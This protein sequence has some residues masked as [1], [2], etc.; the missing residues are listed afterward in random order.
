M[1]ILLG[2]EESKMEKLRIYP[3]TR[4]ML[5]AL[6]AFLYHCIQ[7]DWHRYNDLKKEK[8]DAI[9]IAKQRSAEYRND[10]SDFP[11]SDY[12]RPC[13]DRVAELSRQMDTV[14]DKEKEDSKAYNDLKD[15]LSTAAV[16]LAYTIDGRQ[17]KVL[18]VDKTE[19]VDEVLDFV[20]HNKEMLERFKFNF[21]KKEN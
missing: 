3:A 4:S 17:Y 2:K 19:Y 20:K 12:S 9:R 8:S 18:I 21:E 5:Y 6:K 13:W 16:E 1:F 10:K 11:I 14:L 15:L 7:A